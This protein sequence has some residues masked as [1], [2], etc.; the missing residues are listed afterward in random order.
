[1]SVDKDA[2]ERA[3]LLISS[4]F[5]WEGG[6]AYDVIN[7]RLAQS[8]NALAPTSSMRAVQD[9]MFD[10]EELGRPSQEERNAWHQLRVTDRRLPID[11]FHYPVPAFDLE[12]LRQPMPVAEPDLLSLVALEMPREEPGA[13]VVTV[14]AQDI[15]WVT[16]AEAGR[17]ELLSA[18][19]YVP[20]SLLTDVLEGEDE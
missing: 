20:T 2:N 9:A 5:P 19:I 1:M 4:D 11:F 7:R 17:G 3:T 14:E 12:D 18:P 13:E 15:D 16:L 10:L 8:G 6:C